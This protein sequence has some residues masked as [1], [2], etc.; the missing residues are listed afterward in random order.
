MKELNLA[1]IAEENYVSRMCQVTREI[2]WTEN[3]WGEKGYDRTDSMLEGLGE[4]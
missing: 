3:L 4:G 1:E 2:F